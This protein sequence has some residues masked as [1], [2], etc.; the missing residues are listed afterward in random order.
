M[1]KTTKSIDFDILSEA[2]A[3]LEAGGALFFRG[4]MAGPWSVAI[5]SADRVLELVGAAAEVDTV[6]MFHAVLRGSPTLR[7]RRG[8]LIGL[9]SGDLV[10]LKLDEPHVLS[11][12]RN[13][14]SMTMEAIVAESRQG[15][16]AVVLDA[17]DDPT[18]AR[19]ICGGFFLRNTALHPL[20]TALPSVTRVSAAGAFDTL[21]VLLA[22]LARESEDPQMGSGAVVRKLSDLLLVEFLRAAVREHPPIGWL[23]ALSDPVLSRAIGVFHSDPGRDWTVDSLARAAGVS[24]SGLAARFRETLGE[25]PGR[26]MTRWRMH[27]AMR[28]LADPDLS[29]GE[30]AS[31]VGYQAVESFSRTFKR[32]VGTP[33]GQW[34]RQS[35]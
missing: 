29:L 18:A 13:G 9:S 30:V 25:S 1:T 21:S 20:V 14:R 12:G 6:L 16:G 31:R 34:R 10:L 4:S 35:A 28:L 26:Y 2:I 27:V 23:A 11:E 33:P 32:V 15:G 8:E 17:G 22:I 7:A 19:L 5:P 24:G 3:D